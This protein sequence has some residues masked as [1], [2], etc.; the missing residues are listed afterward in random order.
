MKTIKITKKE[1]KRRK[2][3]RWKIDELLRVKLRYFKNDYLQSYVDW[4]MENHENE[5]ALLK[6]SNEK[7]N[8]KKCR[9]LERLEDTFTQKAMLNLRYL[10]E[11]N[12]GYKSKIERVALKVENSK[13]CNDGDIWNLKIETN[14]TRNV[15]R[16]FEFFVH[17]TK[18]QI[19]ARVIW[20]VGI[21]KVSHF[22]FIT[23]EK[24]YRGF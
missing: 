5:I 8:I 2:D 13:L 3:L 20:V 17:D 21:V 12:E 16:E 7:N 10:E 23:T 4:K 1:L 11:A 19:H 15:G 9:L 24:D 22:R 18:R 14:Y 6:E